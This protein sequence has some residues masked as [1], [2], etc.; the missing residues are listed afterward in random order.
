[1]TDRKAAA[2]HITFE[3]RDTAAA[4]VIAK[5]S[6]GDGSSGS[7]WY[8]GLDAEGRAACAAAVYAAAH[9]SMELTTRALREQGE[10]VQDVLLNR[11]SEPLDAD[12]I[13]DH[14]PVD[15]QAMYGPFRYVRDA[16]GPALA[17]ALAYY[18]AKP[19]MAE[20]FPDVD[21]PGFAR[22]VQVDAFAAYSAMREKLPPVPPPEL[23]NVVSAGGLLGYLDAGLAAAIVIRGWL[24]KHAGTLP[25]GAG[26]L[27][28]GCGCGRVLRFLEHE[29][30]EQ[31][32]HGCDVDEKAIDW[33][34]QYL[35]EVSV[36]ASTATPPL[37]YDAASFD[38]IYSISVFS[39]LEERNH[40]DWI[41]ELA[42][43]S[44]PKAL[45]VLTTHGPEALNG[46]RG[47]EAACANVGLSVAQAEEAVSAL[48]ETGYAFIRQSGIAQDTD[49][50]GMTFITP[51][52]IQDHWTADFEV[53]EFIPQG[54]QSW[55]DVVVL[56]RR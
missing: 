48:E 25:A 14:S 45:L 5:L 39:H 37:P 23:Q 24:A 26:V 7:Q 51:E 18:R 55:Q 19:E 4:Q 1:M 10:E 49:L 38:L 11:S 41:A 31:S 33:C 50:Y 29:L 30:A 20:V 53:L 28:F 40:K 9:Q 34:E 17:L 21:S 6:R 46:I 22:W 12:P 42:R 2:R 3:A 27:D 15:E 32:L 43:V 16:G 52:Y 36:T 8:A 54:L 13:P 44:R 35:L 56:R 47:N